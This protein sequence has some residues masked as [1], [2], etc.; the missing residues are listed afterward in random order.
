MAGTGKNTS[1]DKKCHGHTGNRKNHQ[2]IYRPSVEERL[3]MAE[4]GCTDVDSYTVSPSLTCHKAFG[5][6]LRLEK[7]NYQVSIK[8]L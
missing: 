7:M 5:L 3:E 1:Q 4:F 6:A 8:T 2:V